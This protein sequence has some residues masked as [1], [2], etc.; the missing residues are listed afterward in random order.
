MR[1]FEGSERN[2]GLSSSYMYH[3][4]EVYNFFHNMNRNS[5]D[6]IEIRS[7]RVISNYRVYIKQLN[8]LSDSLDLDQAAA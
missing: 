2:Q 7:T 4:G 6:I 8:T 5:R 1:T 3:A